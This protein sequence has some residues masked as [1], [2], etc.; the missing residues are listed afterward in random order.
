MSDITQTIKM[1]PAGPTADEVIDAALATAQ[2]AMEVLG[3]DAAPLLRAKALIGLGHSVWLARQR[4]RHYSPAIES[5]RTIPL[6]MRTTKDLTRLEGLDGNTVIF[7]I[8]LP[9]GLP[10]RCVYDRQFRRCGPLVDHN[11]AHVIGSAR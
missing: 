5:G 10:Y 9:S 6:A 4:D 11:E 3:A 7:D 8:M 2:D 1:P